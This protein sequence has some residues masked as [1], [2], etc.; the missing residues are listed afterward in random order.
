MRIERALRRI[1]E[2]REINAFVFVDKSATGSGLVVAVKDNID[3][4]GMPTTAGG[5]H[6]PTQP[7]A[8]DAECVRRLR[9]AGCAIVGKTGLY[10]YAMGGTSQNPHQGDVLNPARHSL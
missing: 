7:R 1:D 9:A 6:L 5:R 3:V 10:E 8:R 4:R 2:L